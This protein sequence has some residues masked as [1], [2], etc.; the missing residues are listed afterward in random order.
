M[1]WRIERLASHHDRAAFDCG[2]PALNQFLR[3]HAGQ[4]QRRGLGQTYAA[5]ADGGAEVLGFVT[6]S[7]GQVEAVSLP[8]DL[9]LPRYPIPMLRIGR[10]AVDRSHQGQGLGQDLLAF[11]LELALEFS[12]RVGVYAVLVDAKHD[13]AQA[14]YRQLGFIST[15]DDP[16]CLFLPLATLRKSSA[17]RL[18]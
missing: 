4:Q 2:E 13:R 12:E 15:R 6:L 18:S 10:L 17:A 5:L 11:A 1:A 7:A 9:K 14:F 3:Q 8:P 16:L